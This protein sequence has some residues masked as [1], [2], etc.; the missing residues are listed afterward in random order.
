MG[1]LKLNLDGIEIEIM[2]DSYDS[3]DRD[4]NYYHRL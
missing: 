1:G 3:K 4:G 2:G